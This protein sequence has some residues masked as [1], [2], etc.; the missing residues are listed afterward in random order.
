MTTPVL[1]ATVGLSVT[2]M[3]NIPW[4]LP[5]RAYKARKLPILIYFYR[6][7]DTYQI[8][9]L[10]KGL[11]TKKV[12]A[13]V[14]DKPTLFTDSFGKCRWNCQCRFS[15]YRQSSRRQLL[16]GRLRRD[17]L[18]CWP[19]RAGSWG[20][21]FCVFGFGWTDSWR[22][23]RPIQDAR[24]R[25]LSLHRGARWLPRYPDP[26]TEARDQPGLKAHR[27]AAGTRK[28]KLQ[29]AAKPGRK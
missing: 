28:L 11:S 29:T 10:S 24:T 25:Q 15:G 16:P 27:H 1:S 23:R 7:T 9:R 17:T 19:I 26:P 20:V 5:K 8:M 13:P 2:N 12:S 6:Q 18:E 4:T 22:V 21:A 14:T 3:G